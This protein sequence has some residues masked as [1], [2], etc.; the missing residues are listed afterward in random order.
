M[1]D[2]QEVEV[3]VI[4]PTYNRASLLRQVVR[5]VLNQTYQN[6]EL[7]V[8]DDASLD[9]TGEVVEE[10]DDNRLR[11]VRHQENKG[12]AAARNTGIGMARGQ[13]IAL[14]D[15]DDTWLPQKVER[16]VELLNALDPEKWGMAYC[17]F[18]IVDNR[19]NVL[20]EVEP[21]QEGDLTEGLL[22]RETIIGGSST[23]MI[24]RSAVERVGGFDE[25]FRRFQDLEFLLRLFRHYKIGVVSEPLVKMAAGYNVLPAKEMEG[26]DQKYLCK[27][28]DDIEEF[29]RSTQ[30]KIYRRHSQ[31]LSALFFKEGELRRGWHHM[32]NSW[33][34]TD[35]SSAQ[36]LLEY[37]S[38]V[39]SALLG[40]VRKLGKLNKGERNVRAARDGAS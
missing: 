38:L 12:G 25:S 17:G 27:F 31:F 29:P 23:L 28:E 35:L 5:S 20:R 30:K 26:I 40:I 15:D 19:G 34:Y 10:V 3:S 33:K 37:R 32:R 8:V 14:L 24:R 39:K 11:Y 36:T 18:F 16:Q 1:T 9:H 21:N 22:A 7:I 13:F 4:I 2:N 6:L